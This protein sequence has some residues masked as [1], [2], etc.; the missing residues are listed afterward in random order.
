M[1]KE[2]IEAIIDLREEDAL[3][4]AN[5]M[6]QSGGNPLEVLGAC[7]EAMEVIGKRFE[8]GDFFIPELILAGEIFSQIAAAAK[9]HLQ[10]DLSQKKLGKVIIGTVEG[11]IHD[12]GKDIV[13]FMLD[14]NGF[15]VMDLG[16]NVSPAG[17]VQA[18]KE[19]G[20]EVVGLSG[21]LTLAFDPMKAT[22]A[23]LKEAGLNVK[24]MIGG[25]PVDDNIREYTGADAHGKDAMAAVR[26]ARQWYGV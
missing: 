7:R 6:L 10:K 9:P 20:A 22:V 16:V 13:V 25:G 11:D 21:F 2:L 24:V 4:I 5:Q 3:K 23:A 8:V 18:A 19:T 1:S 17:F 14:A 12:I 26:L 15:E